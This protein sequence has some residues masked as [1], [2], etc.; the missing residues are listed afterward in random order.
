MKCRFCDSDVTLNFLDLGCAPPS[1]AYL[2]A[3][4]L[5]RG[6]IYYPLHIFTCES[7]W[8]VQTQD[9]SA[10]DELFDE[11]YAYFSSVSSSWLAH[12]KK[13]CDMI[14]DRLSL[15]GDS[16]VVELASNDGYLLKNF[17]ATGIPCTGVEPTKSTAEAAEKIGVPSIQEFFGEKLA[18]TM[19]TKKQADLIIGNNVY[20]H[21]PDIRDFTKGMK[22]LLSNEG[23]ITLEF[24]HLMELIKHN[25]FDTVYHEHYSYLSLTAV[26]AIFDA[27]DLRIYDV[28]QIPTH[29]GS[30][31]IY[32]THKGASIETMQNVANL[33]Q[34]EK[35]FGL[36]S[37]AIYAAFQARADKVKNDFLSFLIQAKE[38]KKSVVGYG[39]AAKGN[40]LMNYAGVKTD[41][42]KFACDAAQSKQGKYL[43]GSRIPIVSPD[44]IAQEKPDYVIIFPWNIKQEVMQQLNDI[45]KWGGRFVTF[46]PQVE[47]H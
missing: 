16:F 9:Y 11:N 30:L 41:M 6:E 25:Q 14:T 46:V 27:F 21:V 18:T 34:A 39:A 22:I 28:E 13:Y 24:P 33:L 45:E 32:G 38:E 19:A 3:N 23:T 26:S 47:V 10:A 12:A 1:N 15:S 20:A 31:R 29:G 43:P 7:C 42:I 4:D 2:T 5:Q 8:L 44:A 17:V 37:P 40:T 35:D 36:Q